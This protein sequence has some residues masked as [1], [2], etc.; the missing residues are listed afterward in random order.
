MR[1]SAMDGLVHG[2]SLSASPGPFPTSLTGQPGKQVGREQRVRERSALRC[3]DL[4]FWGLS[5]L[6]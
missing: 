2:V 5:S 1:V 6:I 3:E 4:H